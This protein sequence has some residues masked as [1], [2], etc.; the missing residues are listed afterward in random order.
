M[1]VI[2]FPVSQAAAAFVARVWAERVS[3]PSIAEMRVWESQEV[4]KR[5]N[6]KEFH[7]LNF[8]NDA[9]YIDLLGKICEQADKGNGTALKINIPKWGEK[10]RWT[11]VQCP[12]MKEAFLEMK[13]QAVTVKSQ[14][15]LGFGWVLDNNG[16]EGKGICEKYK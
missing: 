8:P 2:P 6:G 12:L 9:D 4:A 16:F 13:K 11:R 10:E 1:K 15:Q 5:G 14:E 7:Y 3:L